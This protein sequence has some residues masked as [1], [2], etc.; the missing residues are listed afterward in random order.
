MPARPPAAPPPAPPAAQAKVQDSQPTSAQR[1]AVASMTDAA[2]IESGTAGRGRADTPDARR[3]VATG[4]LGGGLSPRRPRARG[5][6][7]GPARRGR[8]VPDPGGDRGTGRRDRSGHRG[9]AGP[10]RAAGARVAGGNSGGSGGLRP[11]ISSQG[12]VWAQ[13]GW[14]SWLIPLPPCRRPEQSA[15]ARGRGLQGSDELVEVGGLP[16]VAVDRGIADVGDLIEIE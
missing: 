9:Q 16:E 5:R 2:L 4:P 7:A 8:R 12:R 10:R 14:A 15:P 1:D 6:E 13:G 3:P 11:A